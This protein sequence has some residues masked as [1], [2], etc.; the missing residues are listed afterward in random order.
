MTIKKEKMICSMTIKQLIDF[1]RKKKHC[2]NCPFD[3]HEDCF[4]LIFIPEEWDAKDIE[5]K[6]KKE[7]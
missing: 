3:I 5:R 4:F 1:C 2:R 6:V 7:L